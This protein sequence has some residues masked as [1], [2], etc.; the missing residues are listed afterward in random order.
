MPGTIHTRKDETKM[1]TDLRNH[2]KRI[3][4]KWLKDGWQL[5]LLI[6]P[7][8][9]YVLLMNYLPL[10]GVQ[11]AFKNYRPS[12]GILGSPWAGL[13]Y[14]KQFIDYP[15]FWLIISNTL[16]ISLYNLLTFPCAVVFALLL[17]EIRNTTLKKSIQMVTYA[18][19]FM[20]TVV[21]CSMVLLFL[22]KDSGMINNLLSLL[23][24]ERQE[25]INVPNYFEDIYVW[26]GVWQNLGWNSIIYISALS[27]VS[28]DQV[29]AARIDGANRL[30][31][32]RHINIPSIMPTIVIMLILACG[33]ILSVGFEKTFLL[34]KSLNLS[35]SQVI[36]TYT[37]EVGLKSAQ[38]SYSS[39]IGLFN[40]VVNFLM[41]ILVNAISRRVSDVSIW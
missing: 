38:Y 27:G 22:R 10:F 35:R 8:I 41:L 1:Q 21:V 25:F 30:D 28:N 33:N 16:R 29:E 13:K 26:S 24:L 20:S 14:F 31:I 15:N 3:S 11:I 17:N 7:A 39:A 23:G 37:Y 12:R 18:P 6:L 4:M 9:I 36:S 40:T 19:H 2:G 5:Y 34:Q 32:I